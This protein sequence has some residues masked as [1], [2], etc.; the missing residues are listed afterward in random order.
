MQLPPVNMLQAMVQYYC[1]FG[2]VLLPHTSN[3]HDYQSAQVNIYGVVGCVAD[4]MLIG[5]DWWVI[6][7]LAL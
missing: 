3:G 2:D 6:I 7:M 4:H 1:L 5:F